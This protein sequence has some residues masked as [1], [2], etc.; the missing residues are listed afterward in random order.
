MTNTWPS[1][2]LNFEMRLPWGQEPWFPHGGRCERFL[3]RTKKSATGKF[4]SGPETNQPRTDCAAQQM[5]PLR[6]PQRVKGCPRDYDGITAG[7]SL[8][9]ADLVHRPSRQY[10]ARTGLIRG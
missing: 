4:N 5:A 8:I 3:A 10:R 6:L 7:V 1:L 9:T 2:S